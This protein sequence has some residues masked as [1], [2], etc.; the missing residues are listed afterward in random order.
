[1][2]T[3]DFSDVPTLSFFASRFPTLPANFSLDKR[4]RRELIVLLPLYATHD[5]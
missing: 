4:V 3:L 5:P 2:L 1:M